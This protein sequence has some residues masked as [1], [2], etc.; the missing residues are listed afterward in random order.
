ME[1]KMAKGNPNPLPPPKEHQFGPNRKATEAEYKKASETKALK[2]KIRYWVRKWRITSFKELKKIAED[3]KINQDNYTPDMLYTFKLV[4]SG[5]LYNKI[6]YYKYE[7]DQEEGKPIQKA[8]ITG[9]DG[10]P[11]EVASTQFTDEEVLK[12]YLDMIRNAE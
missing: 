10:G 12:R 7:R 5:N 2:K 4:M 1:I 9:S 11:I 6:E 3:M 8:Q